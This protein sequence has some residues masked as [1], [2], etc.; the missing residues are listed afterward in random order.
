MGNQEISPDDTS[1]DL[2]KQDAVCSALRAQISHQVAAEIGRDELIRRINLQNLQNREK[3]CLVLDLDQTLLHTKPLHKLSPEEL[4]GLCNSTRKKDLRRWK[5]T[6]VEYLTKLR[7][8]VRKFLREAS[9]LFDMYVYTNGSRDYARIMVDFLD[10]HGVYFGSRII[11]KEDSTVKGQKGLD[12]VPVHKSGVLVLDDTEN[13]W[14]RDRGNLVLIKPYD[15]FA[16]K[17]PNGTISL[18][19]EGTDESGSAGPLSCALRLLKGLHESYFEN[20]HTFEEELQGILLEDNGIHGE[21]LQEVNEE[22]FLRALGSSKRLRVS[23]ECSSLV[24]TKR[25]RC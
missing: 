10:P 9:K 21:Q 23:D 1:R 2:C 12:V 16:P 14:A 8:Y 25:Q 22:S 24:V 5:A 6:G 13:V 4:T 20:Y 15:Y 17:E 19:E 3:L 11:S 7:P 18:S